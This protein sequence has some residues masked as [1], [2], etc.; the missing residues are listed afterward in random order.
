MKDYN[1]M[2]ILWKIELDRQ[3][4]FS[5][6]AG[7]ADLK[8]RLREIV[9]S[10][11]IPHA[12]LISGQPGIGKTSLARALA[13]YIHCEHPVDGDSCGRCPSCLQH[14]SFNNPDMHYVYPVVKL[15]GKKEAYSA[16]LFEEWK[17]MVTEF[18][19]MPYE[20]WLDTIQAGNTQ[21]LIYVSQSTEILHTASLSPMQQDKKIFLI[22]LPE[23]MQL[24]AANK[25]LKEIEEPF[26]DT[27]FI[28]VSNEP[29]KILPTILSRIQNFA[30]LPLEMPEIKKYLIAR[31]GIDD[32][33]ATESARLSEGRIGEALDLATHSRERQEFGD[34]FMTVMRLAYSA[35]LGGL[36]KIADESAS[37]GREKLRR[38]LNYCLK[39]TR[40]NFIYNLRMPAIS[41]LTGSEE[42]FS[43]KFSPFIHAGNV[44]KIAAEFQRAYDDVGRNANSKIVMFDLFVTLSMLLR[45][46]KQK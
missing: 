31:H 36:K 32:F 11:K 24:A 2:L 25:L 13:Q 29:S 26:E 46:P 30:A 10:G 23:K 21:P 38:F 44:E 16:D 35:K 1:K 20:Q 34:V 41:S 28:F 40:E 8:V 39:M 33:T 17:K 22:W 42:M 43:R 12:L 4:Q 9:D 5:D 7:H 19:F 14:R 45:I 37:F 27:L 3:M 18:P 15:K 6:I